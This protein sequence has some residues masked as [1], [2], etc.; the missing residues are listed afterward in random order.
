MKPPITLILITALLTLPAC[1]GSDSISVEDAKNIQHV[2]SYIQRHPGAVIA[3]KK[4]NKVQ[5]DTRVA[6]QGCEKNCNR[7]IS[8]RDFVEVCVRLSG[9]TS[10]VTVR[11][12]RAGGYA[13]N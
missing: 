4:Y 12:P 3:I 11:A 6:L 7:K 1:A 10:G 5:P 13:R 2:A 8:P 9:A